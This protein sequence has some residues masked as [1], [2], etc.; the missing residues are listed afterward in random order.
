MI[1]GFKKQ[2]SWG[3]PTYFREKILCV[4]GYAMLEECGILKRIR[5]TSY[6]NNIIQKISG[7]KPKI[8]TIR[9]DKHNRWKAGRSIQMVYR[10]KNYSIEDHFNKGIDELSKCIHVQ[11]ISIKYG[12]KFGAFEAVIVAIDGKILDE[13][14]RLLLAL[15]DGFDSLEDFYRWFSKDFSGKIIHFTDFRYD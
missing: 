11:T 5:V 3:E 9:E 13:S 6:T 2:F 12:K 4:V 7:I 8:H 10:G 1:L 14:E 15:N